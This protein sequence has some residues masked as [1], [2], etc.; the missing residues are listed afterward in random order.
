MSLIKKLTSE[1][2]IYVVTGVFLL[3]MILTSSETFSTKLASIYGT[4]MLVE[5]T[6]SQFI[7]SRINTNP[8]SGNSVQTLFWAAGSIAALLIAYSLINAVTRTSV[9]GSFADGSAITKNFAQIKQQ[10]SLMS[11]EFEKIPFLSFILFGIIIPI[12]ETSLLGKIFDFITQT[13]QITYHKFS[14]T[15][16][17]VV[18]VISG[19]FTYFHLKVRGIDNNV[20]LLLTFVFGVMTLWLIIKFKEME[21]ATEFHIGWNSL[22]ILKG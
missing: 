8:I 16:M 17:G 14:V 22:A 6:I 13:F 4:M 7:V 1:P 19:L 21:S 15:L 10:A 5:V 20:D 9:A 12:R 18:F 11:I 2:M 3:L